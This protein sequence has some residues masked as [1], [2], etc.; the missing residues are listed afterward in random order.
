MTLTPAQREKAKSQRKASMLRQQKVWGEPGR[1]KLEQEVDDALAP[2]GM[3]TV[4][5][6]VYTSILM[7]RPPA[8]NNRMIVMRG[9]MMKAPPVRAWEDIALKMFARIGVRRHGLGAQQCS[10]WWIVYGGRGDFSNVVKVAE[11]TLVSAGLL[12]DDK[13]IR[14]MHVSEGDAPADK[15]PMLELRIAAY[16]A[17]LMMAD[18]VAYEAARAHAWKEASLFK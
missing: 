1:W 9:M 12:D 11:D 6:P 17:E 5:V 18:L 2:V 4:K 8:L 14:P 3:S 16:P 13:Q 7:P 15:V 10:A